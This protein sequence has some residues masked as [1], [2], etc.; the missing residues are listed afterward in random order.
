MEIFIN[1]ILVCLVIIYKIVYVYHNALMD[2]I[3]TNKIVYVDFVLHNVL[4]V[5]ISM[6]VHNV[7][8][9]IIKVLDFVLPLIYVFLLDVILAL[10]PVNFAIMEFAI[11]VIQI[12]ILNKEVV[13]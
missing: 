9:V 10:M 7:D 11:N 5:Q 1:V 4:N 12:T 3:L 13:Y 2:L 6:N 8:L